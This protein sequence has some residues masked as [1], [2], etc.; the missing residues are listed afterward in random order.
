MA[1]RELGNDNKRKR[2]HIKPKIDK[3]KFQLSTENY[4]IICRLD[5]LGLRY[6]TVAFVCEHGNDLKV[7]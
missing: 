5:S 3:I 6:E 2:K 1:K 7:P 4:V